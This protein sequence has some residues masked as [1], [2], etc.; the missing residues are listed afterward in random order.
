[1]SYSVSDLCRVR[2]HDHLIAMLVDLTCHEHF[3]ERA[4]LNGVITSHNNSI[5][6]SIISDYVLMI[7]ASNYY[8]RENIA[9]CIQNDL[10]DD[11]FGFKVTSILDAL[12][13]YDLKELDRLLTNHDGSYN[14][15]TKFVRNWIKAEL[16]RVE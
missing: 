1:M 16:F 10:F 2:D 13:N 7:D 6:D 5:F 14:Y 11:P 4:G 8:I 15:F 9:A 3:L 12:D